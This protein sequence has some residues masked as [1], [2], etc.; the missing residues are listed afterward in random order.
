MASAAQTE[1]HQLT[2][3][4]L[5]TNLEKAGELGAAIGDASVRSISLILEAASP[6]SNGTYGTFGA[7]PAD[8]ADVLSKCYF[9]FKVGG[10]VMTQGPVWSFP[11]SGGLSG[12]VAATANNATRGI[13]S[14]GSLMRGRNLKVPVQIAR[15]DTVGGVIG[16]GN[17]ASLVMEN[18]ALL[19]CLLGALV[20][21]DVR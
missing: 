17:S 18:P 21:G 4:E 15:N 1:S 6:K 16:T 7:T 9:Q 2:H 14:N 8:V 11:A 20:R 5:T 12:G 3:S 10:K 19:T 13:A